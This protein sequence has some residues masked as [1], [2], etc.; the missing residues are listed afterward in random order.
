MKRTERISYDEAAD[1]LLRAAFERDAMDAAAELEER[2][3]T[4]E[5][6]SAKVEHMAAHH[7]KSALA[8]LRHTARSKGRLYQALS[9]AACLMLVVAGVQFVLRGAPAPTDALTS[10][11]TAEPMPT[12]STVIMP[13]EWTGHY[14]PAWLP[15]GAMNAVVT[16]LTHNGQQAA[17]TLLEGGRVIF[18]EY[19][20]ST[21]LDIPADASVSYRSMGGR[22]VM[23]LNAGSAE[24]TAL[25]D[26]NGQTFS[27]KTTGSMEELEHILVSVRRM[28]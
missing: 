4:D 3:K 6:L 20:A 27:L 24:Q 14:F 28:R 13:E 17:Y 9:I 8:I 12:F 2:L 16:P 22:T 18:A 26:E 21:L 23:L 19:P 15:T 5:V 7:K 25:W 1:E 10:T 11:W